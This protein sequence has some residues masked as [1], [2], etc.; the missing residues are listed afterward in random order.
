MLKAQEVF[1]RDGYLIC[2]TGD[3]AVEIGEI[4]EINWLED[5]LCGVKMRV[6]GEATRE[7]AEKQWRDRGCWTG[8]GWRTYYKAIAE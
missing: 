6:V 3:V 1:E 7:E 5:P 8:Y 2:A 4:R